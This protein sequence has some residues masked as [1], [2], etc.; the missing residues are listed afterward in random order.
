MQILNEAFMHQRQ[1]ISFTFRKN[2][3]Q[4]QR[5]CTCSIFYHV[6]SILLTTFLYHE[7]AANP[8][9]K[10]LNSLKVVPILVPIKY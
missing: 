5:S 9:L 2:A 3:T 7:I 4:Q 10:T 8:L 1:K 6:F